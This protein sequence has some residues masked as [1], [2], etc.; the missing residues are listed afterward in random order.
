M[1]VY[2]VDEVFMDV[3]AYL[4]NYNMTPKEL[5]KKIVLDV[6]NE[7]GITATAGIGT[8]LYLCKVA[9]DVMA[10]HI[11]ADE[12][13]VRIAELNEMTYR[14]KLW[15]HTPIT[16]FWRVGTGY[17]KKL[18]SY[19]IETMGDVARC[20]LGK[21]GEFYSEDLLY[22]LFGVNAELLIDHA[23]GWEPCT[24]KDIKQYKP[25]QNSLSSGQVLSCPYEIKKGELIV[26]E[27]TDLLV[28]ELVEKRLVTNQVVLTVG[29]DISNLKESAMK[30][31][32]GEVTVDRYGRK[33][34]K[35]AHGTKN[36]DKYTSST[37]AIIKA[38]V[39]LYNEITDKNLLIRRLTIT[40]NHVVNED[41]VKEDTG[42]RQMSLFTD[43][44]K[45]ENDLKKEKAVQDAV[46]DIKHKYGKNA[47][48][49]GMNLLEGATA[50]QR[51]GQI[52]GHK[53]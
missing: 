22:K 17:S 43:Y 29:Y 36:L 16:D 3:T 23:W 12:N 45:E 21:T 1:H 38:V 33:T 40:V 50:I 52:G 27:M 4:N 25:S 31:Y 44:E 7:T 26:K 53:A 11:P 13:G 10:K 18:A 30:K 41:D 19:G 24:I 14:E 2:S 15:G 47:V 9:M 48:I 5:A 34:P 6:L 49:K 46:I 28:L 42:Y 51:N 35:H 20:S 32:S 39:E 8:N 37:Q